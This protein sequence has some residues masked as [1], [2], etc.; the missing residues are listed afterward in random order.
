MP[1]AVQF[2][3]GNIGRGFMA[4]LFTAAGYKIDFV[5][6]HKP[7]IAALQTRD[8]YEI[9]LVGDPPGEV[10]I[11]DFDGVSAL[12]ADAVAEAV[13]R[14]DIG[15]T[16]VGVAA[17]PAIAISIASGLLLRRRRGIETPLNF[18]VCENMIGSGAHLRSLVCDAMK[19]QQPAS[20]SDAL[21]GWLAEHAGF[22]EA[23]VARMVPVVPP[24]VRVADPLAV[25]VEPF[26]HLPVDATAFRGEAPAIE[27]IE[28]VR[29]ILAY[30]RRK[31]F[32]HN[33][34]H[35]TL[36]YLGCAAG[37]TFAWEAIADADVSAAMHAS[38]DRTTA[39]LI[40]EYPFLE[41]AMAAHLD[42]L[43]PR[44]ASKYLNDTL[45]RL[46]GD[47]IRKLGPNDRL[48][49]AARFVLDHDGDPAPLV[50]TIL[51]AIRYVNPTDPAAVRLQQVLHDD[52]L[53]GVLETVCHLPTDSPLSELIR[54]AAAN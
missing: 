28:P 1:N 46:A 54:R 4:D 10:V 38:L 31:L 18:I 30:Q 45:V 29:P 6:L 23:V 17:L 12:D 3:A 49:G 47:P 42:D 48:V 25:A 35:A 21:R 2:G 39:A 27:G 24:E 37:L 9:T 33:C 40:A 50:R 36:G 19:K 14:A 26:R 22:A 20:D 15:A 53:E 44:I 7:T 51:T 8:R 5:D 41:D 52:G 11:T 32:V 13:C 16:A 34:A 43:L